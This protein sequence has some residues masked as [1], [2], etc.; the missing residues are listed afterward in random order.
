LYEELYNP[1]SLWVIKIVM[2]EFCWPKNRKGEFKAPSYTTPQ[3]VENRGFAVG[4]EST[5]IT[6]QFG[7]VV[8]EN[9]GREITLL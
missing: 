4:V 3:K 5:S 2:C 6:S 7:F 8:E 1:V 9:S